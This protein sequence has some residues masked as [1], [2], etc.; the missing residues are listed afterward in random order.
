VSRIALSNQKG[1]VGKTTTAVNL[2][3]AFALMGKRV[4]LVDFDPQGNASQFLG[5]MEVDQ[6][7]TALYTSTNLARGDRPFAPQRDVATP[8]LDLVPASDALAAVE[9]DLLQDS[10]QGAHRLGLALSAVA[11]DY[12][13]ILIDCPPTLGMLSINA[14]VAATNVLV[15][16]KL[17]PA[18]VPGAFHLHQTIERLRDVNPYLRV[19]GVVGTFLNEAAKAPKEVLGQLRTLFGERTVCETVIHTAQAVDDTSGTGRP[20]VL[21]SPRSRGAAE[22]TALAQEVLARV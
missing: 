11:Q 20:I 7:D 3:V 13:H 5:L 8:Q 15:P 16:V 6:T 19:A 12:D 21:A 4:L 22:Y 2:A 14:M 1:G 9:F 17:S 10:R 18:S